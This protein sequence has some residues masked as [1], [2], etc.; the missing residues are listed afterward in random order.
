MA[1][2]KNYS[3]GTKSAYL[4][5]T[6]STGEASNLTVLISGG[7]FAAGWGL[8][9]AIVIN[10]NT[11]YVEARISD[12]KLSLQSWQTVPAENA[13]TFVLSRAFSSISSWEFATGG[14]LVSD[15]EA[16]IG[17][18]YDDTDYVEDVVVA[19]AITDATHYRT[20]TVATGDRHLGRLTAGVNIDGTFILNE[21]YFVLEW[22]RIHH[23]TADSTGD[24]I[25]DISGSGTSRFIT[26]NKVL[27]HDWVCVGNDDYLFGIYIGADGGC[28]V[29]DTVITRLYKDNPG[30]ND[31]GGLG[32]IIVDASSAVDANVVYNCT[33][34]NLYAASIF[35]KMQGNIDLGGGI[36]IYDS[37]T[38]VKNN[39]CTVRQYTYDQSSIPNIESGAL[40][41]PEDYKFDF[42]NGANYD[43]GYNCMQGGG[44]YLSDYLPDLWRP[45]VALDFWYRVAMS[46]T[47]QY[48]VATAPF[49]YDIEYSSDYGV[50]WQN[51]TPD[52]TKIFYAASI[53]EDGQ[54]ILAAVVSSG[55]SNKIHISYDSGVTWNTPSAG[56]TSTQFLGTAI[57]G[58]GITMVLWQV[59]GAMWL[60]Q[61]A[62]YTWSVMTATWTGETGGSVVC[63]LARKFKSVKISTDGSYILVTIGGQATA[64]STP[65][66][67][68]FTPFRGGRFW[69][70]VLVSGS[71]EFSEIYQEGDSTTISA[72]DYQS[73]AMSHS[74]QHMAVSCRHNQAF[75]GYP[76][77]AGGVHPNGQVYLSHDYGSTWYNA[78]ANTRSLDIL[79]STSPSIGGLITIQTAQKHRLVDDMC[80][81]ITGHTGN[82]NANS[83]WT[84]LVVDEYTLTLH[85][86]YANIIQNSVSNATTGIG[87]VATVENEWTGLAMTADGRTLI[88]GYGAISNASTPGSI[89]RSDDF[90][91]T[92]YNDEDYNAKKDYQSLAISADG[93]Y[94]LAAIDTDYLRVKKTTTLMSQ[95]AEGIF[96]YPGPEADIGSGF[97]GYGFH[98]K[99]TS[100]Y[101]LSDGG[102]YW[103][104]RNH[105]RD[106]RGIA[107]SDDGQ[108]QVAV[109]ESS[110]FIYNS[111]DGGVFWTPGAIAREWK[112]CAISKDGKYQTAVSTPSA[113]EDTIYRSSDY[114]VTWTAVP[115]YSLSCFAV[116][117]SDSGQYQTLTTTTGYIHVSINYGVTWATKAIS[118]NWRGIAMSGSG[119]YQTAGVSDGVDG[120]IYISLDFGN[121]WALKIGPVGN[122]QRVSISQS[123]QYQL[124]AARWTSG[125]YGGYVYTSSDY[126][127]SW[128]IRLSDAQRQWQGAAMSADGKRQL[129]AAEGGN[130]WESIDYGVSW[131]DAGITR[132]WQG[133]SMSSDSTVVA[134]IVYGGYIL[135][136]NL[137]PNYVYQAQ[138]GESGTIS[139]YYM[140]IMEMVAGYTYV[141]SSTYGRLKE[142]KPDGTAFDVNTATRTLSVGSFDYDYDSDTF[143]LVGGSPAEFELIFEMVNGRIQF[144]TSY[145]NTDWANEP[146]LPTGGGYT[147]DGTYTSLVAGFITGPAILLVGGKRN[148]GCEY[149]IT[150]R[151]LSGE[152]DLSLSAASPALNSGE[153][154][155]AVPELAVD[156]TG[157]LRDSVLWSMGAY[158]YIVPAPPAPGDTGG[159][160]SGI[161]ASVELYG[162]FEILSQ[163]GNIFLINSGICYDGYGNRLVSRDRT[164]L[165]LSFPSNL[166]S[167]GS[168]LAEYGF[169]CVKRKQ[170]NRLISYMELPTPVLPVLV[171]YDV[172][173]EFYISAGVLQV[174][175]GE[176]YYYYP[177][178][179]ENEVIPGIVLGK[180]YKNATY[181]PDMLIYRSP[182]IA[183]KDGTYLA[184]RGFNLG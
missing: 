72:S 176:D 152:L 45:K 55:F 10:A 105:V 164:Q 52:A 35:M 8:G 134:G 161:R 179:D 57:S 129:L 130:V 128:A 107:I 33:V 147:A 143:T 115:G 135:T 12:Y 120:N 83:I 46:S 137:S 29:L 165:T 158:P 9:D 51:I 125:I 150:N 139:F 75:S 67:P 127:V 60:S 123:G 82:T 91:Q 144:R 126:G 28:R 73:A 132:S 77:Q 124:I 2:L 116:A 70:G 154:L 6:V 175:I 84:V 62:G 41:Q 88:S 95:K 1:T 68:P 30:D 92:W 19:G 16:I 119:K 79:S 20:L 178:L 40:S 5:G 15:D 89:W 43:S 96:V 64:L 168:P 155:L 141:S 102:H 156:I 17:V 3:I 31:N 38:I 4:S 162:Q 54:T 171:N 27:I 26:V 177:T 50:T 24:T 114:G 159:P 184:T 49:S 174:K 121:S 133:L 23:E 173:L 99:D 170:Q 145:I 94:M 108:Y 106:W 18:C 117:M 71:Y 110:G 153:P 146:T 148:S 149:R 97:Y 166:S 182:L 69:V 76:W 58:D 104:N 90:G 100:W 74:G 169:L 25:I 32:G 136:R 78:K 56:L 87:G 66:P 85:F 183:V 160:L 36:A 21:A 86:Y 48:Q 180:V 7:T 118:A 47:G 101:G 65:N 44:Y 181:A 151:V 53:S 81:K 93:K 163:Q 11:Y 59:E 98:A 37:K 103:K 172:D 63:Q 14:D 113:S 111:N 167:D 22:L 61:D 140:D 80:I 157:A 131:V 142:L 42:T 34:A 138:P 122:F 13:E 39:I 109:C 112:Y